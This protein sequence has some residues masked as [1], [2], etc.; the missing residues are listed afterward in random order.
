MNIRDKE[1]I[2]RK[3]ETVERGNFGVMFDA[4][5]ALSLLTSH[6]QLRAIALAAEDLAVIINTDE[7]PAR[8]SLELDAYRK[9]VAAL[10]PARTSPRCNSWTFPEYRKAAQCEREPS[11]DG[12][13]VA[14]GH[15]WADT[16]VL[17]NSEE[18]K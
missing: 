16:S 2:A 9:L 4:D 1:W 18:S 13:H 17:S 11:H 8:S 7:W 6:E 3:R 5:D 10:R 15:R 12:E 14:L